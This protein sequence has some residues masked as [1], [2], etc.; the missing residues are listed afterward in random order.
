MSA[1]A[2]LDAP[3]TLSPE[4]GAWDA[5][6]P[7]WRQLYGSFDRLGV[8]VELHQFRSPHALD[9]GRSFH[10]ESVEICLNTAG[11][12]EVSESSRAMMVAENSV[13]FYA[14]GRHRL[15]A[16]R[17]SGD[18]HHFVTFEFSREF[19]AKQLAGSED[20]LAPALRQTVLADRARSAVGE[21][22]PLTISQQSLAAAVSQPPVIELALPLWY[23]SKVIET[24]AECFFPRAQSELFCTRQKRMGR[25]RVERV[26]AILR[27]QLEDPP[28]LE[29]L[30]REVG[31]SQFYLSRLFSEEMRMTI[32][33]YLRQIRMERAAALLREGRCNVT[34]AAFAV[35]YSSLGHFS[36]SFCEVMGCCPA[37]YPQA[38]EL[39][40]Q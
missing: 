37:L 1:V 30:G 26:V 25:E 36:K 38:R 8:S 13:G 34:E 19:L 5:I 7:G 2:P 33:Q 11:R 10:P 22:R 27:A 17:A 6:R 31:V 28:S 24:V 40:R 3:P 32:P 23:Q 15:K 4:R 9:W 39:V 35:G 20:Q 14:V 21:A 29:A 12:G 16:S 18:Q